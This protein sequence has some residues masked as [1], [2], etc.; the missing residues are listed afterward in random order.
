MTLQ[1]RIQQPTSGAAES[2]PAPAPSSP[3][4]GSTPGGMKSQDYARLRRWLADKMEVALGG[5]SQDAP[6]A[7]RIREVFDKL[8]SK[9]GVNLNALEADVLFAEIKAEISG[10]GPIQQLLDDPDVSEVMVNDPKQVYIERKGKL[11]LQCH[12]RR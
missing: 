9:A 1:D 4:G 11:S 10:F 3:S 12:F 6:S 5:E 2:K 8:F 7:P